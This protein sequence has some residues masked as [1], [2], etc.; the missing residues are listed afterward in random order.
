MQFFARDG[1]VDFVRPYL[2]NSVKNDKFMTNQVR[3]RIA[4]SPTGNPHLGTA[5]MA[6]FNLAFAKKHKG[7]MILRIED[8]D[9]TRSNAQSEKAI[10]ES[11]KWLGINWN[12]GP[13]K[14]GNFGPY[15]QSERKDIHSKHVQMLIDSGHAYPCF[16][17]PDRLSKLRAEQMANKE[18]PRYDGLCQKL[19]KEEA[20]Q[21]IDAGE[22]YV[23]RL[24]V[25]TSGECSFN[26]EL[27]GEVKI[28]WKQID[29]QVLQKSDGF[30]TYH[31]ANVVDDYLM[32]ITHVIRGEEWISSTPKHVLL[33]QAFGWDM[34]I[35]A[36][37]PLLRNPDKSKLSKRKNPTGINYYKESGYLPEALSNYLGMMGYTMS[38]KKEIFSIDELCADFEIKRMSLG[39]PIF[40]IS[41]LKWLNGRYLRE[42]LSEDEV[43]E[44]LIQW[45]LNATQFK[46]IIPHAMQRLENFSDFIS[47]SE[48]LFN[49]HPQLNSEKLIGK[50]NSSE[51]AKYLKICEWE[52]EKITDW[53]RDKIFA[54]FKNLAEKEDRK[55]KEILPLF[56]VTISGEIVSLPLFDSIIILGPD[57]VRV[58]IRKALEQ[59]ALDGMGLSKKGVKSLEKEYR[60]NYG[61]R[62]D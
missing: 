11:L 21:K 39:G 44:R 32:G 27:R 20:K 38:D 42:K 16:C 43:V 47:I 45:K 56:F 23:V 55:L 7:E 3:T 60:K 46:R 14:P 13:D 30:P 33:Y 25:P 22:K 62:I 49:E 41:K 57:L 2:I 37:L 10:L 40:D 24:K 4:P 54:L 18:T 36:H 28:E 15:R 50:L 35:F 5:Y 53:E 61:E 6:L 19:S 34:P 58:R 8:T 17:T 26:D 31:L 9:Q 51:A 29:H 52:L 12:E 1:L 59:L 48:F